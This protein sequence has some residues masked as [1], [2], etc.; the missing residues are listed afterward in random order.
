MLRHRAGVMRS[1]YVSIGNM[2][3]YEDERDG[4]ATTNASSQQDTIG[5]LNHCGEDGG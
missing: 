2:M 5:N 3:L 1:E 4:Y